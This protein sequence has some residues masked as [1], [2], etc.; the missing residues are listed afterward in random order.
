MMQYKDIRLKR[1][2]FE[3]SADENGKVT[4]QEHSQDISIIKA[5]EALMDTEKP[6]ESNVDY[7]KIKKNLQNGDMTTE[8]VVDYYLEMSLMNNKKIKQIYKKKYGKEF[9]IDRMSIG[10]QVLCKY[11]LWWLEGAPEVNDL[12]YYTY[13]DED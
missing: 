8:L 7:N 4:M 6:I 2:I 1:T 9:K 13:E 10:D 5:M 11:N 12:F 3:E